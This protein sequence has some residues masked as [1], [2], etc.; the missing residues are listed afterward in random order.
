[1]KYSLPPF[2]PR[3]NTLNWLLI[4][5]AFNLAHQPHGPGL[6]ELY[7]L[8]HHFRG[9]L[10]KLLPHRGLIKSNCFLYFCLRIILFKYLGD[11]DIKKAYQ[12]IVNDHKKG[13]LEIA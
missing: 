12:T 13:D 7:L 4:E 3:R 5:V 8:H 1:M 10:G 6:G 11:Y 9:C 2:N